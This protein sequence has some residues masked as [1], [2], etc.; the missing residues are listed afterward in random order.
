M[1]HDKAV[2]RSDERPPFT[3]LLLD[4]YHSLQSCF[5][6]AARSSPAQ[7]G[8][9]DRFDKLSDHHVARRSSDAFCQLSHD[10][11]RA[12]WCRPPLGTFGGPRR[13][14]SRGGNRDGGRRDRCVGRF[15]R[16]GLSLC[17]PLLPQSLPF[18]ASL[19]SCRD[20]VL[21]FGRGEFNHKDEKDS[22]ELNVRSVAWRRPLR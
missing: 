20:C 15:G 19:L 12:C 7:Q 16:R 11:G 3:V 2:A 9:Q 10:A 18:P 14:G 21:A 6:H 22:V 5:N 8:F 4:F 1:R 13:D 17:T